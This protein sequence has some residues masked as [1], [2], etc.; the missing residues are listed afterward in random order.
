[1]KPFDV[2]A[3]LK[4]AVLNNT[5]TE[6]DLQGEIA[7]FPLHVVQ[8]M[9]DEQVRQGN[10][11]SPSV[12]RDDKLA[13]K[14][15]G[16]F[17]W[18]NTE[19]GRDKGRDFWHEIIHCRNFGL[20]PSPKAHPHAELM[21]EYAKIARTT[22]KPWTHFEVWQNDSRVWKAI[23]LPVRFY[24]HM[25]YR[26]KPESK[27]I[28]IGEYDVP[29][30]VREP[31]E[32][33]TTCWYPKLSNI[34]LIDGYIWCNDDTDVRMLSNGLIHLTAEAAKAHAE[35]LLSLTKAAD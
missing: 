19:K 5:V 3:A 33:G 6:A 15:E 4:G 26:L 29:E 23:H 16:G 28:R 8:A 31:L 10:P 32:N 20:I 35:A 12:F 30:P 2:E 9:C 22:D 7:D 11:F 27:T 1:M 18:A 17:N 21:M 25:E 14:R 24:S 34:D 13:S